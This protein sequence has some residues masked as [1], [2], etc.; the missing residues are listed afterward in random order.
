MVKYVMRESIKKSVVR[1]APTHIDLAIRRINGMIEMGRTISIL[2]IGGGSGEYWVQNEQLRHL[3]ENQNIKVTIFDALIPKSSQNPLLAYVQGE[4]PK[5]LI[6]L[7]DMSFDFVVAFDVIEHVSSENGFLML[8]AME[9]ISKLGAMIFTPNGFVYQRPEPG[10]PFN[11][12]I[13]GWKPNVF[14]QFGWKGIRGHSG[15]KALFGIYGLPKYRSRVKYINYLWVAFLLFSQIL[16]FRIPKYSY[17]I[18]AF[19][20]KRYDEMVNLSRINQK[21]SDD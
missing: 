16:V 7:G 2:D 19:Y 3:I 5:D 1:I 10:N 14:K 13:S 8:Y 18:S 15:F 17:A 21:E 6:L 12:H 4:A 11:A 20:V 9:R